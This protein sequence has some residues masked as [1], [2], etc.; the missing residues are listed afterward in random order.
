MIDDGRP[1][2][3]GLNQAGHMT[4]PHCDLNDNEMSISRN[5]GALSSYLNRLM[6]GELVNRF[7]NDMK[8]FLETLPGIG[9]SVSVLPNRR[10]NRQRFL[11]A[12]SP[13]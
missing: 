12:R 13:F 9:K 7:R 4:R 11:N 2:L 6:T 1:R 10:R 5:V 3:E 8:D